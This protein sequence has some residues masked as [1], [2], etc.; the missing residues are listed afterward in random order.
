MGLPVGL[1]QQSRRAGQVILRCKVS[2]LNGNIFSLGPVRALMEFKTATFS[3]RIS[4]LYQI[5]LDKGVQDF[6][7]LPCVQDNNFLIP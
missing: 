5:K 2:S 1:R 7:S 6:V 4:F 3:E